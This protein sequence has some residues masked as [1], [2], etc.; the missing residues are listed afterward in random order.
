M[1][2]SLVW[3]FAKLLEGLG[4]VVVLAGVLISI[5]LGFEDEGLA[6]M[7]Q[8]FQGLMVGGSLF[9]VGYLLERWARTR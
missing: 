6:S 2:K 3:R 9:L 8:E 5:N 4:L 7:A 1:D